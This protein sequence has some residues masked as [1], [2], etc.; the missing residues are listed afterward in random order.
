MASIKK[1][2]EIFLKNKYSFSSDYRLIEDWIS[3]HDKSFSRA[4][5]MSH[6]YNRVVSL[7]DFYQLSKLEKFQNI[8]KVCVVSGSES[9]LELNFIN[10]KEVL[11]TSLESG[12][13]LTNNWSSDNF[14]NINAKGRFDLVICNQVLEH[15][16]DPIKAFKNLNFLTKKGGYIWV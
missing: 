10:S 14:I 7:Y 5:R 6:G 4:L 1:I 15:V 13:D 3:T 2:E 11:T 8:N 16:P 9:E 12:Y